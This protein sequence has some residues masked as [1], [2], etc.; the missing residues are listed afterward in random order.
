[1]PGKI[2][3]L[4][5]KDDS[6]AAIQVASTLKGYQI[7]AC[8]R[9]SIEG[10]ASLENALK[11]IFDQTDLRSDVCHSSIPAEH[12]SYRNLRLPFK[13]PKK[14]RQTL[15]FEIETM[16]P[17]HIEDLLVDF[18]VIDRSDQT[19]LLAASVEK[20]VISAHVE[21]LKPH[22]IDPDVLD[23]R[24]VPAVLWLLKQ[25]GT[26]DNG[27]FL[28][29]D[30]N[31]NTMVLF[32]KN[33]IVLIRTFSFNGDPDTHAGPDETSGSADDTQSSG[34]AD[35]YHKQ[36][37]TL[38]RNTIHGYGE[39]NNRDIHPDKI[40]FTGTEAM[41]PDTEDLLS[42][43][44]DV[45]A[46][47][48]NLSRNEKVSM[49]ATIAQ[50]WDPALMDN[51]LALAL[52]DT[53]QDQGFNFRKDEFEKKKH[54]FGSKKEIRR[55][56]IFFIVLLCFL[57]ANTGSDYYFL[58]KRYETLSQDIQE[59]FKETFPDKKRIPPGQELSMM[60]GEITQL[61]KSS[62]SRPSM[63]GKNSVLDLLKDISQRIPES[64]AVRIVRMV[65]DS[66]TV[67]IS[68]STDTFNTVDKIKNDLESSTFYT[69]AT[70]SSAKLDR[71]GEKVEFEIKLE[72][73]GG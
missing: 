26:P 36:F 73:A 3:G 8:T 5:I 32:L 25:E 17:F 39:Q 7:T 47:Q 68:G 18:S 44:F 64:L 66:E 31:K 1:M 58:K 23:I 71:T 63:G 6:V 62:A 11:E 24:C 42:R 56:A 59:V 38:I 15:P 16:V 46:E 50:A 22:G 28:Q 19:D 4:D 30:G 51:A 12:V 48:V 37:F 13:D 70:I 52:R 34:Q 2:L 35:S 14:I 29:M 72:R 45:P 41:S 33:R 69:A 60:K 9:V 55:A 61:K 65:V 49:D 10:G 20:S 53:R 21:K 40:F 57:A 43:F 67:R 54:Y 27:L